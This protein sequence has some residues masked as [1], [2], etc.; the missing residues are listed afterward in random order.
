MNTALA[1][2]AIKYIQQSITFFLLY[3]MH[4]IH[5][6]MYYFFLHLKY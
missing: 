3:S 5:A 2:V 4:L 6:D 1:H